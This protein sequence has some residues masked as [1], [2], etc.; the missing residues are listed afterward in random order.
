MKY[1]LDYT[2]LTIRLTNERL[3][4]ILEHPEMAQMGIAIHDTLLNPETVVQSKSDE[5]ARLYYRYYSK[6]MVGGKFLCVIVKVEKNDAFVLTAYL[7]D[8]MKKGNILWRAN[9]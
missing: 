3:A 7:T 5:K 8:K 2:G 1:L 9:L 4:H 6:T